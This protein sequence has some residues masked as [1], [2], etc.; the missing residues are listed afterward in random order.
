MHIQTQQCLILHFKWTVPLILIINTTCFMKAQTGPENQVARV[1]N[2]LF[3][4][5]ILRITHLDLHKQ[6]LC[7]ELGLNK[8]RDCSIISICGKM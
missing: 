8:L 6:S 7:R 2:L 3:Q 5:T 4:S 1:S